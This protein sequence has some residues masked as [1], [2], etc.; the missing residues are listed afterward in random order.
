MDLFN[1]VA[2][3]TSMSTSLQSTW[4]TLGLFGAS[5]AASSTASVFSWG[6]SDSETPAVTAVSSTIAPALEPIIEEST[7]DMMGDSNEN[8]WYGWLMDIHDW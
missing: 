6:Y 2:A 3:V 8:V 1:G 4:D 7:V 5:N